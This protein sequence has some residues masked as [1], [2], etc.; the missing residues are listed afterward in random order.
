VTYFNNNANKNHA[1]YNYFLTVVLVIHLLIGSGDL[2]VGE[3]LP[4]VKQD[5]GPVR[6]VGCKA[7]GLPFIIFSVEYIVLNYTLN[8]SL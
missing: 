6:L 2:Y 3:Y 8:H 7:G 4:P 1:K 5:A